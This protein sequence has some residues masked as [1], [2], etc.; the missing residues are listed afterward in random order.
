MVKIKEVKEKILCDYC[1]RTVRKEKYHC[2]KCKKHVCLKDRYEIV[3]YQ[4]ISSYNYKKNIIKYI[5]IECENKEQIN[6]TYLL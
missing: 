5:C 3:Y 6:P 2:Y 1:K 4:K